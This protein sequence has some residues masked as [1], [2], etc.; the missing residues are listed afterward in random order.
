MTTLFLQSRYMTKQWNPKHKP[1]LAQAV[2]DLAD[3]DTKHPT[4]SDLTLVH[5]FMYTN[6]LGIL[7]SCYSQWPVHVRF[8]CLHVVFVSCVLL[9]A[10]TFGN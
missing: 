7:H 2:R 4:A 6:L 1:L 5:L 10:A 8:P 3:Y 9:Q